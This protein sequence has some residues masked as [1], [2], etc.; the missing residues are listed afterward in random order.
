MSKSHCVLKTKLKHLLTEKNKL[1]ILK[2]AINRTNIIV[3][4]TYNFIKLLVLTEYEKSDSSDPKDINLSNPLDENFIQNCHH[5]ITTPQGVKKAGRQPNQESRER[6]KYLYK[7]YYKF[8]ELGYISRTIT[9]SNN[10]SQMLGYECVKMRTMYSNNIMLRYVSYV[11][12][13]VRLN[14]NEMFMQEN[15]LEFIKQ[16]SQADKFELK[17][18][19][20]KIVRDLI[21]RRKTSMQCSPKYQDWVNNIMD[22]IIPEIDTSEKDA[23]VNDLEDKDSDKWKYMVHMIYMNRYFETK[24]Y[25]I[26]SPLC[27]R[28]DLTVKHVS[29][30]FKVLVELFFYKESIIEFKKSIELEEFEINGQ[31]FKWRLPNLSS[32]QSILDSITKMFPKEMKNNYDKKTWGYI[33][34]LFKTKAFF[35]LTKLGSTKKIPIVKSSGEFVFNNLIDTDGYAVSI[36]Y[37]KK[38]LYGIK[39]K[40]KKTKAIDVPYLTKLDEDVLVKLLKTTIVAGDMG[41][42]NILMLN[43]TKKLSEKSNKDTTLSYTSAMR[44]KDTYLGRHRKKLKHML[45]KKV[46]ENESES[47]LDYQN[48]MSI[49]S[50]KSSFSETF[51]KYLKERQGVSKKLKELYHS[52][53]Q[54]RMKFRSFCSKKSSVDRLINSIS[55]TFGENITLVI[56]NWGRNPN[57]KYTSPTPGVGLR[58]LLKKKFPNTYIVDEFRTS[59]VCPCCHHNGLCHPLKKDN[60]D[61]HHLLR[62]ENVKCKSRWWNRDVLGSSNI[63]KISTFFLETRE[64]YAPFA[65]PSTS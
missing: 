43:S 49:Y 44:Q 46:S 3:E 63:H 37:A 50:K 45:R 19:H 36:H 40:P 15:G 58:R 39:Y 61:I 12:K 54:Q 29:I 59:S 60:K 41:K 13:F 64:R 10:L 8:V 24:Q 5:V 32:K 55:S 42:G 33:G 23:L 56:G 25:K 38:S 27:V 9:D 20:G 17:K 26:K 52:K 31:R 11:T 28:S 4:E 2:D 35:Y 16:A 18:E 62:C 48:K 34:S 6:I 57:L 51:G 65:R 1:S 22:F 21:N 30:D 14:L 47:F 7:A 53:P